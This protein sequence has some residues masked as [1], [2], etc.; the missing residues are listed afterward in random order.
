MRTLQLVALLTALA[1]SLPVSDCAAQ[2]PTATLTTIYNFTGT[3]GDAAN[4]G[5][6]LAVGE[7]GVLLGTAGGNGGFGTVLE[8]D[9]PASPGAAW[10][11]DLV[12]GCG[13]VRR[14]RRA[15]GVWHGLCVDPCGDGRSLD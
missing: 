14:D 8:L 4:P 13:A 11:E 9:P 6:P 15:G 7:H 10:T 3:P 12:R 2:T 1:A 5:G